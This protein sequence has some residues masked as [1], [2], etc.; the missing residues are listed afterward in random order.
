[1]SVLVNGSPTEEF[2]LAKGL[3]Q[4]DPL[5]PFLFNIAVQGLSCM[6]QRGCDLGLTSG[7]NIGN[8]GL[9][10]SHLQFADD[11][12]MFSSDSLHSMQNIKRI[13][14]CFELVSGL[15]VNFYKSSIVGVG[16][17]AHTCNFTAQLLRCK[18]DQLPLM[19][20]GLPIGGNLGRAT[21]W[22]P[23]LRNI[24]CRLASWKGRF[25]YIGGCLCLIKSVL[26]NL[27]IYY[28]SM[29]PMP[30]TVASKI[31]QKLRSFL[32]SGNEERHKI[33]NVSWATVTLPKHAGGSWDWF[34]KG[35]KHSSAI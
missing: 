30:V 28:L 33:C 13:L 11:T 26:S 6:L 20:L 35:Q 22:N 16:V 8:T 25:L 9:V 7:I 17:A 27:P 32:W 34:L 1:M 19:Y 4:G 15:K 3:R 18:Q 14:L 23:I 29:F 31:D 12:L 2:C 5:S 24:S 21:M 10:I